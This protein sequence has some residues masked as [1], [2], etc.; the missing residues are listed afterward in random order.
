MTSHN[1]LQSNPAIKPNGFEE[2]LERSYNRN[3]VLEERSEEEVLKHTKV[4][5]ENLRKEM[6]H[7]K[8]FGDP[9]RLPGWEQ[10]W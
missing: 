2:S 6:E 9:P 10:R 7:P 8:E 5:E 3:K 1:M 4:F